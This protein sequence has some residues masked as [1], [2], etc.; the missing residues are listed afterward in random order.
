MAKPSAHDSRWIGTEGFLKVGYLI[1]IWFKIQV[2]NRIP[3]NPA[4]LAWFV[5]FF[6]VPLFL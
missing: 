5:H 3:V 2:Q 1:I 4:V 6:F